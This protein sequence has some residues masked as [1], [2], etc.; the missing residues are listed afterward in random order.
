LL[1]GAKYYYLRA[2]LHDWEDDKAADI[3]R[4]II[5]AMAEDSQI[6]IDD[7]ALPNTG[8]HWWSTCIDMQMY[9]M[10]GAME[11]TVDQWH[12]LLD[13]AGLKVVEIRTYSPVMRNSVIVAVP[14]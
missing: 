12:S 7:L 8:V 13:K 1:S 9:I 11:R 10:H 4:N 5:P 6:L 14:K 3:L 2:I